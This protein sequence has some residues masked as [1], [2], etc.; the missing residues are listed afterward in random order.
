MQRDD[1]RARVGGI[2][3]TRRQLQAIA[4]E[5]RVRLYR[6]D[7]ILNPTRCDRRR[8]RGNCRQERKTCRTRRCK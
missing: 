2:P 3:M 5:E 8:A 4:C 1:D 6:R 7:D